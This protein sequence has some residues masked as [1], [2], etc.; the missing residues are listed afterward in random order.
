VSGLKGHSRLSELPLFAGS[1]ITS[2]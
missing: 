1:Y 2:Y